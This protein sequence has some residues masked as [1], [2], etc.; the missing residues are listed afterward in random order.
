MLNASNIGSFYITSSVYGSIS[1]TVSSTGLTSATQV[2]V[3]VLST[4]PAPSPS[5]SPSPAPKPSS[6]ASPSTLPSGS[7]SLSAQ[8]FTPKRLVTVC[9]SRC[10]Y[11]LL[12]QALT[13]AQDYDHITIQAGSY[14]DCGFITVPHLWIQGVGGGM[15][16]LQDQT[17]GSKGILVNDGQDVTIDNIEFSGMSTPDG[18]NGAGIRGETGNL[19]FAIAIFTTGKQGSSSGPFDVF[20][21]F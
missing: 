1:V 11:P 18:N 2:E 5:V 10:D 7:P 19:T 12:S 15:A 14:T 20:H 13:N 6:S 16:H 21:H 9:P 4:G 17:C 3:V 8:P